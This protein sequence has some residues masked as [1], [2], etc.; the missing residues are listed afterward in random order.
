MNIKNTTPDPSRQP[1]PRFRQ[2]LLEHNLEKEKD[3]ATTS[4]SCPD[5]SAAETLPVPPVAPTVRSSQPNP[6]KQLSPEKN[7]K[8]PIIRKVFGL[9]SGTVHHSRLPI[10]AATRRPTEKMM[11][12]W[13]NP[14]G[15]AEVTG[16]LGQNH[17][18]LHDLIMTEGLEYKQGLQRELYITIDPYEI[19]KKV[20]DTS[21]NL[22]YL[23]ELLED[24]RLAKVTI[25]YKDGGDSLGGIVSVIDRKY[26]AIP[27]PGGCVLERYL[28]QVTISPPWMKLYDTEIK[29][30][31]KPALALILRMRSG[32]SQAMAR[33]FLTHKQN[34]TMKF[35]DVLNALGIEREARQ[36]RRDVKPDLDLLAQIGITFGPGGTVGYEKKE[37][38]VSFEDPRRRKSSTGAKS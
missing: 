10:F 32:Y 2:A 20:G 19:W 9:S 25:R 38:L 33:L 6:K 35:F 4:S 12:V 17:R 34:M 16:K 8:K 3:Q 37:G 29:V 15:T 23:Y 28:W 14:W 21:S 26:K 36:V 30:R 22:E 1:L 5:P 11:W 31:C 24:M 27:G 7:G 13:E 18:D